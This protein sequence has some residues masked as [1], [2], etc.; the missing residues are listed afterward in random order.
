MSKLYTKSKP[1]KGW[2]NG[3][4]K[5]VI[6]KGKK[7]NKPVSL[8]AGCYKNMIYRGYYKES[9]PP[10]SYQMYKDV[11]VCERWVVGE[12]GKSGYECF[13]EDIG[14][15]PSSRHSIDR[16]NQHYVSG[17]CVWSDRNSQAFNTRSHRDSKSKYKGISYSSRDRVWKAEITYKGERTYLG[18]FKSERKAYDAYVKATE[19]RALKHKVNNK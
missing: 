1:P 16:L 10:K 2:G 3:L 13:L 15:R 18:Q 14:P 9:L 5:Q 7:T 8:E 12:D 19:E 17:Q 11:L 4:T 6:V